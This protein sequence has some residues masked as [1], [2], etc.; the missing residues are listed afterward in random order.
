MNSNC[1][2][3]CLS[4]PIGWSMAPMLHDIA[5]VGQTPLRSMARRFINILCRRG[6]VFHRRENLSDLNFFARKSLHEMVKLG[7]PHSWHIHP[8]PGPQ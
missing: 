6:T 8:V 2:E 7:D 4:Q 3:T 1:K 5:V